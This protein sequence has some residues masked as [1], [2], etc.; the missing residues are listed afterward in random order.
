MVD[1]VY[2][3]DEGECYERSSLVTHLVRSWHES[4]QLSSQG[5]RATD[6]IYHQQKKEKQLLAKIQRFIDNGS[7]LDGTVDRSLEVGNCK[8]RRQEA[9]SAKDHY[10]A[11]A[12]LCRSLVTA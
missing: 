2:L 8:V 1:P 10:D 12:V 3:V 7:L 6:G 11:L 5:G 4:C 9:E